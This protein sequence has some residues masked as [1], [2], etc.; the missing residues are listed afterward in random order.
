M[1]TDVGVETVRVELPEVVTEVGEKDAVAFVGKPLITESATAPVKPP[2]GVTVTVYCVLLPKPE[3]E[4][5]GEADKLKFGLL[6]PSGTIC[7][8]F[9]GA[10]SVELDAVLG[11]AVIVKPVA[12]APM[13]NTT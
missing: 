6:A 13:V 7:K 8:P 12:F 4:L 5:V 3:V 9:R 1:S 2:E 11:I 10:R